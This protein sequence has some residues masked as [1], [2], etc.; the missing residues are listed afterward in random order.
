MRQGWDTET[1]KDAV[2]NC[3][4][5]TNPEGNVQG[6]TAFEIKPEGDYCFKV[7]TAP[8]NVLQSSC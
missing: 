1:L 2:K 7:K 3:N 6:C 5:A 4:K 8:L